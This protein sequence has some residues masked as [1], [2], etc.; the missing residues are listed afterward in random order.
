[1][2]IITI[3]TFSSPDLSFLWTGLEWRFQAFG[4]VN[5]KINCSN[6]SLEMM[7]HVQADNYDMNR[8]F[9]MGA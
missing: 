9:A 1:M 8:G 3:I 7:R 5:V 6:I 2:H 4:A